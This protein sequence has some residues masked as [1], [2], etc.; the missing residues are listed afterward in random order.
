MKSQNEYNMNVAMK[1]KSINIIRKRLD[2]L[3]LKMLVLIKKRNILVNK[4]LKEKKY[5]KEIVDKKRIKVIL[6]KIRKESI[7][8]K[9]DPK[10]TNS[11][12]KSMIKAFINFEFRNFKKK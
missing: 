8:R 3:D 9:I 5:K 11:I 12:W 4:I 2:K 1:N 6:S 10:V 7:K